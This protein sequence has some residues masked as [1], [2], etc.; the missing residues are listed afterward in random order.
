MDYNIR[1]AC[2]QKQWHCEIAINT[3]VGSQLHDV[4][5]MENQCG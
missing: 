4:S 2:L 5:K 3:G 1:E